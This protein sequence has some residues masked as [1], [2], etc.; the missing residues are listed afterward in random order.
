MYIIV[1]GGGKVG[2]YLAKELLEGGH[3]VLIIEKDAGRAAQIM[4]ELGDVVMVGDGC[5]VATLDKAGLARAEMVVAVTGDDE[6]NLVASQ[7]AKKRFKVPRTIARINNPKNEPIF[8][9]LG[10]DTTVSATGVILANLE[11]ELPAH[12]V[13]PL[14]KLHHDLEVVEVKIPPDAAVVGRRIQDLLLPQQSLIVLIV[15]PDGTPKIPSSETRLQA[16]D[17]LLAVT[18]V[19]TV[20]RLREILTSRVAVG[21]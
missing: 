12:P 4:E 13:I 19:E 11:Q 20:D 9:K 18:R 17:A 6:D 21:R 2:F 14:L 5:E 7:I 1:I 3:E 8:R 10:I 16:D 15:D